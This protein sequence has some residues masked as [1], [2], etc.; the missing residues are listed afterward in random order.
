MNKAYALTLVV[1][2]ATVNS[3]AF[4]CTKPSSSDSETDKKAKL[5]ACK[6]SFTSKSEEKKTSTNEDGKS[7]LS[8]KK[9][10]LTKK[11]ESKR[12]ENSNTSK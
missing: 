9:D 12:S 11:F 6:E 4:A 1:F 5:E 8:E 2:L 3:V 7:K 10:E